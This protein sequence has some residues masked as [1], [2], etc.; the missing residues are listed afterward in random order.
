MGRYNVVSKNNDT[1][2]IPNCPLLLL[3]SALTADKERDAVLAQFKFQNISDRRIKAVYISVDCFGV[4]DELL[5]CLEKFVYLDLNIVASAIFGSNVP[6]YLPNKETRKINIKVNLVLY[7]DDTE[8]ANTDKLYFQKFPVKAKVKDTM[9]EKLFHLFEQEVIGTRYHELCY[10]QMQDGIQLCACGNYKLADQEHCLYC[11]KTFEWWN[12]R[13]SLDYLKE[14]LKEKEEQE[15]AI[16][17]EQEREAEAKRAERE[18]ILKEGIDFIRKKKIPIAIFVCLLVLVFVVIKV[19]I[20]NYY[21]SKGKE[22]FRQGDYEQ[23]IEYLEKDTGRDGINELLEQAK[24]EVDQIQL[25]EEIENDIATGNT[26]EE[27]FTR[28]KILR[29]KYKDEEKA[30]YYFG[31]Y[32]FAKGFYNKAVHNWEKINNEELKDSIADDL[33]E[34]IQYNNYS[35][36]LNL[37]YNF[38]IEEAYEILTDLDMEIDDSETM[39]EK[40]KIAIDSGYLGVWKRIETSLGMNPSFAWY[41]RIGATYRDGEIWFVRKTESVDSGE[42]IPEIELSSNGIEEDHLEL[43][44]GKLREI[45]AYAAKETIFFDENGNM[46]IETDEETVP[47]GFSGGAAGTITLGGTWNLYEFV[48]K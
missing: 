24:K 18:R 29:S 7:T 6:V 34:A 46:K 43:Q 22:A 33:N 47:N 38:S 23:A 26:N 40:L 12:S 25:V 30:Y 17:L 11:G 16:K 15:Q 20:P 10:P 1:R 28:I 21:Y 39:K 36:A 45:S 19:V 41:T 4:N 37:I 44:D 8:W 14:K 48:T 9:D 35:K 3:S 13:L 42:E 27:A 5:E 31:K 32:Y 2:Y